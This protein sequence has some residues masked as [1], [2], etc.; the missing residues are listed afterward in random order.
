MLINKYPY[1]LKKKLKRVQSIYRLRLKISVE[2]VLLKSKTLGMTWF[3]TF[4]SD[5]KISLYNRQQKQNKS[6]W[7]R[8][9]LLKL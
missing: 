2:V 7:N 4:S 5:S 8:L 3:L 9:D 1:V 6:F